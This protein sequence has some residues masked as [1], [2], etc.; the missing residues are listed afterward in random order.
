MKTPSPA[1]QEVTQLLGDWS[2][3]D[4]RALE[5]L[6]PLLQPE[7]HRLAHHYM[8]RE[9]PGQTLQTTAL[10]DEAYLL[11]VDNKRPSWHNR[12]H[13]VAA[14][15]QL[16]RRIM[17]D[18]ARE[19]HALKR[20]GGMQKVILDEAASVTERRSE[21]LL[22]LDEAL[23]RL[24]AQDRRKSQIVELRYFGGLTAEETAAFLQLSLR[25]VEREWTMAKAWLYRALSGEETHEG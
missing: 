24:A 2:S 1:Q 3:G 14:A 22:A 19:R 15:A 25:T 16:M 13:F 11:L 6:I 18:H 5:K 10:L 7:L 12:T 17:V 8:S 20:G 23:E 9:C 4:E 21:E